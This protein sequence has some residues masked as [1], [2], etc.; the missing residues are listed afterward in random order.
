MV[1]RSWLN[2]G[3]VARHN[4]GDEEEAD[5]GNQ[6]DLA[7]AGA[8]GFGGGHAGMVLRAGLGGG[9]TYEPGA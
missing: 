8:V 2:P 1:R 9:F 7:A 5:T 4:E 3:E 6:A